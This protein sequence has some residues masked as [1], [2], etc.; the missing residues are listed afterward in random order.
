MP[1]HQ[2][3][4]CWTAPQWEELK[5]AGERWHSSSLVSSQRNIYWQCQAVVPNTTNLPKLPILQALN[6]SC[7]KLQHNLCFLKWHF[8]SDQFSIQQHHFR[9]LVAMT[10]LCVVLLNDVNSLVE[11][12]SCLVPLV[13]L[14]SKIRTVLV[15][16]GGFNVFVEIMSYTK[17]IFNILQIF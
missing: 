17:R 8:S 14:L 16:S 12:T 6:F 1:G 7:Q 15:S 3:R 2:C 13:L 9:R 10:M 5:R 11:R 4:V